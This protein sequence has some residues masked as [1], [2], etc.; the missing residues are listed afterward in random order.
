MP[1]IYT[2]EKAKKYDLHKGTIKKKKKQLSHLEIINFHGKDFRLLIMKMIQDTGNKLEAKIDKLQEI[3]SKE[4]QDLR[5]KQT[6]MQNAITE[7][8]NSLEAT[9]GRI[10]EAE[11]RISRL[12]KITDVEQ[13][14]EKILKIN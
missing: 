13:K 7:I 9:S 2:N 4:I 6:E 10:Q 3:L 11:E 8:K 1:K 5:I 12:M 14:R